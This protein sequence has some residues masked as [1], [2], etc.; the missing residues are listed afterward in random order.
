MRPVEPALFRPN[1]GRAEIRGSAN[2]W[3]GPPPCRW[4]TE[5]TWWR[6]NRCGAISR[7]LRFAVS[8]SRRDPGDRN[9]SVQKIGSAVS[10]WTAAKEQTQNNY[11]IWAKNLLSGV[12]RPPASKNGNTNCVFRKKND[13]K[14][15]AAVSVKIVRGCAGPEVISSRH[16]RPGSGRSSRYG[17]AK[18]M[19]LIIL[20][21]ILSD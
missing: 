19:V 20:G 14:I 17:R 10:S 6:G 15:N 12:A 3:R 21:K 18:E 5:R 8:L 1:P 2:E 16:N 4:Q 13:R 9:A 11:A 7:R